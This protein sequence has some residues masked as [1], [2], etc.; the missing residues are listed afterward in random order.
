MRTK[1]TWEYRREGD[2]SGVLLAMWQG[3]DGTFHAQGMAGGVPGARMRVPARKQ[4][5]G[6][7]ERRARDCE[8]KGY[9]Q[10]GH[11]VTE[12]A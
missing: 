5:Q 7:V 12:M 2:D 4:A 10:V 11:I 6:W 3:A 9:Q 1:E 8:A